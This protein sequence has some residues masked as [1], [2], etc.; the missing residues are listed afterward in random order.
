MRTRWV[1]PVQ[2]E[3]YDG[4]QAS[5]SP[6][7]AVVWFMSS[8]STALSSRVV[9]GAMTEPLCN[10][11]QTHDNKT[12]TLEETR[13]P[14][15]VGR[16][17]PTQLHRAHPKPSTP[18]PLYLVN[19]LVAH[20]SDGPH[21]DLARHQQL[22]GRLHRREASDA[23]PRP[24]RRRGGPDGPHAPQ[25]LRRQVRPQLLARPIQIDH[26]VPAGIHAPTP[27]PPSVDAS[28]VLLLLLHWEG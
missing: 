13:H 1:F 27:T 18:P 28:G 14:P 5:V 4:L 10:Y 20:G 24:H 15:T 11:T 21:E 3:T 26:G 12:F 25:P 19:W 6:R 8:R 22:H 17:H 9:L 7:I 16:F 2:S 23:L